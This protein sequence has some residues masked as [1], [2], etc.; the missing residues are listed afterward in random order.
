[1]S[2]PRLNIIPG[3]PVDAA[4]DDLAMRWPTFAERYA[5][6]RTAWLTVAEE[7]LREAFPFASSGELTYTARLRAPF[8]LTQW[9]KP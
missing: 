8:P 7:L 9:G 6:P 4:L 3:S 2:Y 1:M 5:Y